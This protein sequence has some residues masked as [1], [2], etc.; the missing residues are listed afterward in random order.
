MVLSISSPV[1]SACSGLMYSGVPIS[2]PISVNNV[3]SVRRW[4]TAFATP[5]SITLGTGTPSCSMTRTFEG[6]RSR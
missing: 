4:L 5:K 1:R 6:F 2:I 3:L